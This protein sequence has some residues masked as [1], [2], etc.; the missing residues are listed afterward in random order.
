MGDC[1]EGSRSAV[2]LRGDEGWDSLAMTAA[3]DSV[4]GGMEWGVDTFSVVSRGGEGRGSLSMA[5]D[6]VL[7][8]TASTEGSGRLSE[9][10]GVCS[11]E[12]I[13]RGAM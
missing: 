4:L 10:F 8:G 1:N 7:C 5:I 13:W 2:V 11:L 9:T 3:G 6:W 12:I